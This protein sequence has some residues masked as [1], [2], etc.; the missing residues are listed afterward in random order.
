MY[1]VQ[2]G[3]PKMSS[4]A[5]EAEKGAKCDTFGDQDCKYYIFILFL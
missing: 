1:T 3:T 4:L 5:G 2:S